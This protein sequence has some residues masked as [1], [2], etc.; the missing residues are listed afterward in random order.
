MDNRNNHN[1]SPVQGAAQQSVATNDVVDTELKELVTSIVE[2]AGAEE[3]EAKLYAEIITGRSLEHMGADIGHHRYLSRQKT[4]LPMDMIM[5]CLAEEFEPILRDFKIQHERLLK[6]NQ[7]PAYMKMGVV[8]ALAGPDGEDTAHGIR[9]YLG[10]CLSAI[11]DGIASTA[12]LTSIYVT[13][14]NY[15]LANMN[16]YGAM[17]AFGSER[18]YN[19][20]MA[21][22]R[23]N[24]RTSRAQ[25]FSVIG[26]AQAKFETFEPVKWTAAEKGKAVSAGI[27][28]IKRRTRLFRVEST[29]TIKRKRQ[30]TEKY[31]LLE[32]DTR[33][34]IIAD[35]WRAS[36]QRDYF[37]CTL[38]EPNL[39]NQFGG[40]PYEDDGTN[41]LLTFVRRA[42]AA[43]SDELAAASSRGQLDKVY[44]AVNAQMLTPF[45]INARVYAAL[46]YVIETDIRDGNGKIINKSL[47]T[48][49]YEIPAQPDKKKLKKH[50]FN[51][52]RDFRN[53]QIENALESNA[54][55]LQQNRDI[56]FIETALSVN[57]GLFYVP[58]NLD[59][60]GRFTC[61]PGFHYHRG[62]QTRALFMF[63]RAKPIETPAQLSWL[64]NQVANSGDFNKVSKRSWEAKQQ[65]VKDNMD[66]IMS[67]GRDWQSTIFIGDKSGW[68]RAGEPGQFLAACIEVYRFHKHYATHGWGYK[69]GLVC[70]QDGSNS[71]CQHYGALSLREVDGKRTNLY[72]ATAADDPQDGYSDIAAMVM[73][74]FDELD[75]YSLDQ[76]LLALKDADTAS[77]RAA[78]YT[79]RRLNE[80]LE[81]ARHKKCVP[82]W[83]EHMKGKERDMCKPAGMTFPYSGTID[84]LTSRLDKDVMKPLRKELNDGKIKEH[85]FG[86]RYYQDLHCRMLAAIQ[87][88]CVRS[89]FPGG[90]EGMDFLVKVHDAMASQGMHM[91]WTTPDGFTAAQ[92]KVNPPTTPIFVRLDGKEAK[93]TIAEDDPN[94]PPNSKSVNAFCPNFIHSMDATALRMAINYCLDNGVQDVMTIHDSFGAMPADSDI[95]YRAVR[96]TFAELYSTCQ[97]TELLQQQRARLK[98][99][100]RDVSVLD[101]LMPPEK[102]D[103]N[104]REILKFRNAFA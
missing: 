57:N 100:G 24:H 20:A 67:V 98:A 48:A 50:E 3:H 8:E 66:F 32:D 49:Y 40:K 22:A 74:R 21:E 33:T 86:S 51:K 23:Q 53:E 102:C 88:R 59:H 31:F 42:R 14:G 95:M 103:L 47:D 92:Y 41:S 101:G 13:A 90:A 80:E 12:S 26:I 104:L 37:F 68:G 81:I 87:W 72:V 89:V 36:F 7:K 16:A 70:G 39:W 82:L 84:G 45:R 30:H 93:I 35:N 28:F 69:C 58:V 25:H 65:W 71:G 76:S 96:L 18:A 44:R 75:V 17:R 6:S 62:D 77:I 15:V 99:A 2:K 61:I 46:R 34:K 91:H 78:G 4:P 97:F 85:P 52:A 60:R 38:D 27:D 43:Q 64:Y 73:A 94:L 29:E 54:N 19:D 1:N 79:R 11:A 56:M 10:L 5:S 83:R 55:V 9:E 63:A